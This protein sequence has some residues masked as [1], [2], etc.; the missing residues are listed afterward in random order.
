MPVPEMILWLLVGAG[1]GAW[2]AGWRS[3]RVR[4][5]LAQCETAAA[6]AAEQCQSK[7]AASEALLADLRSQLVQSRSARLR[8]MKN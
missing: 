3:R 5:R 7:L 1:A 6:F 8:F 4:R 2:L